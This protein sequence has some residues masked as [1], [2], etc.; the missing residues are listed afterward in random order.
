MNAPVSVQNVLSDLA[1]NDCQFCDKESV[2]RAEINLADP[3]YVKNDSFYSD[4]IEGVLN[5]GYTLIS[6][7]I[8]HMDHF[9]AITRWS[10][11]PVE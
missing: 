4:V 11:V 8:G 10:F 3:H 5:C 1:E 9:N 2:Y 7:S 6:Q